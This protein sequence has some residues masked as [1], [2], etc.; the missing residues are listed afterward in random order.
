MN[1]NS[2]GKRIKPMNDML[3]RWLRIGL[4]LTAVTLCLVMSSAQS[5]EGP[6]NPHRPAMEAFYRRTH[7]RTLLRAASSDIGITLWR[8]QSPSMS[9]PGVWTYRVTGTENYTLQVGISDDGRDPDGYIFFEDNWEFRKE[10]GTITTCDFVLGGSYYMYVF[11]IDNDTDE[12]IW[13]RFAFDVAQDS[14]RPTL[15]QR[16]SEIVAQCRVE[17]DDWLTALNLHD[18]LTHNAYYDF[19]Y[20][21]YGADILLRGYGVC[22]SY[23]KAYNLRLEAAGIPVQRAVSRAHAWNVVKLS[24]DWHHVDATWDD[25][26]SATVPLSG[27]ESHE[28][29][30][31]NDQL[32]YVDSAHSDGADT[33]GLCAS[34][35]ANYDIHEG[36]WPAYSRYWD[37]ASGAVLDCADTFAALCLQGDQVFSAPGD[38][39]LVLS[40]DG[41]Y[42]ST[43]PAASVEAKRRRSIYACGLSRE[44]LWLPEGQG[45]LDVNVSYDWDDMVFNLSIRGWKLEETGTLILPDELVTLDEECLAGTAATT[46]IVNETCESIAARAFAGS[47]AHV[48]FLPAATAQIAD[49]A[50]EGCL[51]LMIIAPEGSPAAAFAQERGILWFRD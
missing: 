36:L 17:D 1:L 33:V 18:W 19:N 16:V 5:A 49:T 35:D 15:E 47:G 34:L 50:F 21:Y 32:L 26:G 38:E 51:P 20:N 22:D 12:Y 2:G 41:G 30:C 24:G 46:V 6:V 44:G 27:N 37:E 10:K 29:F 4:A 14:S 9:Q 43:L 40:E 7:Q 42:T 11:V 45:L 8:T 28:Y 31:L 3:K 39:E 25:P 13:R 48:V 23:S